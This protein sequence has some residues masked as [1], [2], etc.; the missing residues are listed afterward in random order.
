MSASHRNFN[1]ENDAQS[2]F[3]ETIPCPNELC[4]DGRVPVL[5]DEGYHPGADPSR[6]GKVHHMEDCGACGGTAEVE[7]QPEMEE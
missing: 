6:A 5:W 1:A 2:G 7:V 3:P 4:V